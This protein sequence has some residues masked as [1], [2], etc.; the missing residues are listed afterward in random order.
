MAETTLSAEPRDQHGSRPSRR[1][2]AEGRIPAVLY[3]HG[4]E[5][6]SISVDGRELRSALHGDAGANTLL[7]LKIGS[8]TH[9]A[10]ARQLQRHP[11][12]NTVIHVDFQVV[13]R[14]ER[15]S[16]EVPIVLVG[17]AKTV[18][19]ADGM[20][21]QAVHTLTVSAPASDIPNQIEVDISNLKLGESIRV[22]D[23]QMPAGSTTDVDAEEPVVLAVSAS[24][25]AGAEADAIDAEQATATAE[26]AAEA[27]EAAEAADG[28]GAEGG[29]GDATKDEG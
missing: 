6:R 18:T 8:D 21:E 16:V 5:A 28:D 14:T 23:L 10:L 2:R 12:R 22:G 3:G 7:S 29:S 26:A 15:I 1:A 19:N 11:V 24:D 13:S 9:L 17:E 27:A 4:I 20:V 25:T